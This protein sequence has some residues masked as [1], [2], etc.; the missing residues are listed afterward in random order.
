VVNWRS[1]IMH[2]GISI[3]TNFGCNSNCWYCIWKGHPDRDVKIDTDW[4]KLKDFLAAHKHLKKVSISGGGD[5][6]YNFDKNYEWWKRLFKCCSI[7]DLKIDIHTREKLYDSY[8]WKKINKVV[9][10]SDKLNLDRDYLLYLLIHTKLRISH[11]VTPYTTEEVV[12]E[13]IKF[14]NRYNCQLTFKELAKYKDNGRYKELKKKFHDV[15]FL[16]DCDY[17]IY[18]FPDNTIRDR[19]I[20]EDNNG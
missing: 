5:P 7:L 16:D 4:G 12:K 14:S 2:K 17:N 19:F 11:V 3:I 10:S 15:Y 13:Y 8:F 18:Y 9:I 20:I 6:L 1:Y